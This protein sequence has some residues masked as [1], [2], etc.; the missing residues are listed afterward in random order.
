VAGTAEPPGTPVQI[1]WDT[2]PSSD[3]YYLLPGCD[4]SST[5]TVPGV[6]NFTGTIKNSGS[7]LTNIQSFSSTVVLPDATS[8]VAGDSFSIKTSGTGNIT[9]TVFALDAPGSPY[10]GIYAGI[11]LTQLRSTD[12]SGQLTCG[13]VNNANQLPQI[14]L[15]GNA[16]LNMPTTGIIDVPCTNVTVLGNASGATPSV[17]GSILANTVTM[18]A[19]SNF[20]V[21]YDAQGHSMSG[22]STMVW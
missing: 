20:T 18:G 12:A 15:T 11:A 14:V 7:T 2:S 3:N 9:D 4:G 1:N 19:S 21:E 5:G 13:N 6:F 22:G 16:S 8:T 17:V 10:T